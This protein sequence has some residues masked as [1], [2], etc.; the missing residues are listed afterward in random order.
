MIRRP[1]RSTR[2]DTLFPDTTLFALPIAIAGR[3][4]KVLMP[5]PKNGLF[6]VLD[7][8]NGR[9]ISADPIAKVTWASHI[10]LKTG[11]PVENPKARYLNGSSFEMWPS[12][13]GAHS[14]QPMAYSPSTQLVY[15]PV[16]EGGANFSAGPITRQ[17]WHRAKDGAVDGAVL[18]NADIKDHLKWKIG[19]AHV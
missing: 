6:Y 14:W 15:I 16:I 3:S 5:A 4:R 7:R 10:D 13:V 17:N 18:I 11:R 8:T 1:P 9:L 2:T 19:R 12:P